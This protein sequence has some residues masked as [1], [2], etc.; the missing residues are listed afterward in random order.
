M[1]SAA[2]SVWRAG[3]DRRPP[4]CGMSH[5]AWS[6]GWSRH[7]CPQGLETSGRSSSSRPWTNSGFRRPESS[8]LYSTIMP[9][10]IHLPDPVLAA[11]DERARAQ[12]ISRSR[13]IARAVEKTLDAERSWRP[14]VL[15]AFRP[16]P[17]D[18][19]DRETVEEML[20]IIAAGRTR[21]APVDL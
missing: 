6:A 16:A 12:G 15:R 9:T 18:D 8:R 7:R 2:A 11:V 10:T 5:T 17:T 3:T 19:E 21:K 13:Y 14:E 4:V 20:A 1:G